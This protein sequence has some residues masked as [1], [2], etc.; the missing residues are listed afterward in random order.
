ME[1]P[2]IKIGDDDKCTVVG[3]G[4]PNTIHVEFN[5]P[6]SMD[7][8]KEHVN[9]LELHSKDE[10]IKMHTDNILAF[11]ETNG[12]KFA[13]LNNITQ[14][15]MRIS[16]DRIMPHMN[17]VAKCVENTLNSFMENKRCN[18]SIHPIM[19]GVLIILQFEEC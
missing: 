1:P 5:S 19:E 18:V 17:E 16:F 13:R 7:K 3:I 4:Y 8:I 11:I 15:I 10:L 12:I 9:F 6:T 14:N 2:N